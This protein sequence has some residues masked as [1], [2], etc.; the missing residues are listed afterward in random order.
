MGIASTVCTWR[1]TTTRT[2]GNGHSVYLIPCFYGL[3]LPAGTLSELSVCGFKTT[4]FRYVNW[5]LCCNNF[6][7]WTPM[8]ST[9]VANFMYHVMVA[10]KS[11]QSW[12]ECWLVGNPSWFHGILGCTGLSLVNYL[13]RWK[14]FLLKLIQSCWSITKFVQTSLH[15]RQRRQEKQNTKPSP[16]SRLGMIH[17]VKM[18]PNTRGAVTSTHHQALHMCALCHEQLVQEN[19]KCGCTSQQKK[20]KLLKERLDSS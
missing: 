14:I 8:Y 17:Q 5:N 3:W 7:F 10:A 18:K 15:P 2:N 9:V 12:L 16:Q 4:C 13:P 1:W 6:V 19:L 11:V 20:L